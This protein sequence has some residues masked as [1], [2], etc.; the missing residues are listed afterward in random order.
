[1]S[2]AH[3]ATPTT[4]A[5][6]HPPQPSP[7]PSPSPTSLYS[8]SDRLLSPPATPY[9]VSISGPI[10]VPFYPRLEDYGGYPLARLPQRLSARMPL[11]ILPRA[12]WLSRMRS[13]LRLLIIVLSGAVVVTLMHTL[14]IYRG[15]RYL[16]LRK[17]EIP[18]V[19]PAHTNLAPTVILLGVATANFLAS[20]AILSLS[21]KRSFRRPIRSRDL[22]RIVAGSFGVVLWVAALVVFHLLDRASKASLGR[23]SCQHASRITNGRFQYRAVCEEQNVAFY[24]AIGA[25]S[26]ELLTLITLAASAI[27]S[28]REEPPLPTIQIHE[29]KNSNHLST[30]WRPARPK[31]WIQ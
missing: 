8:T 9:A 27:R 12:P 20:V 29:K 2:R 26:A 18:M 3:V 14:E 19:W 30:A 23:Y 11:E 24:T 10:S 7:A 16:E 25:A 4:P 31:T 1:M 17:G 15:N 22:Y 13:C 5:F 21:F 28:M 6:S